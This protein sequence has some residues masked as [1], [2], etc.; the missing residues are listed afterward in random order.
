[1]TKTLNMRA[2]QNLPAVKDRNDKILRKPVSRGS[3]FMAL[4]P[5]EAGS[6]V[7]HGRAEPVSAKSEK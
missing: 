6:L 4:N 1:M 5:G 3:T 7:Q 2:L